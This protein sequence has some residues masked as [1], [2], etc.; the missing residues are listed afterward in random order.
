[1]FNNIRM[2]QKKLTFSLTFP[3]QVLDALVDVCHPFLFLCASRSIDREWLRSRSNQPAVTCIWNSFDIVVNFCWQSET[4]VACRRVP[5]AELP[6]GVW[7]VACCTF[8]CQ[9]LCCR[10][11]ECRWKEKTV[12]ASVVYG[13][14]LWGRPHQRE[15]DREWAIVRQSCRNSSPPFVFVGHL[16]RCSLGEE[17]RKYISES[18]E[19]NVT[20][21]EPRI[22]IDFVTVHNSY[23]LLN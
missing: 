16:P 5:V 6:R 2:C 3:Q 13:T 19:F 7:C 8:S 4:H 21:C 20:F 10:T 18:V 22:I 1:M 17:N 9:W 15:R 14:F 12:E 23:S 11:R